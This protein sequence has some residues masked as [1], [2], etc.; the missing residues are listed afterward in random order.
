GAVA[1]G[2][3]ITVADPLAGTP[4]GALLRPPFQGLGEESRLLAAGGVQQLSAGAARASTLLVA[5]TTP[6]S[7]GFTLA[8]MMAPPP[9]GRVDAFGAA[10]V[11]AAVENPRGR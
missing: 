1:G 10:P 7:P 9:A 5:G 4:A 3:S 11:P 2:A 8:D 6:P